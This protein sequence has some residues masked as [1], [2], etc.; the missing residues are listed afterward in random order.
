MYFLNVSPG[1]RE[2]TINVFH[3]QN[4]ETKLS[5]MNQTYSKMQTKINIFFIKE[6]INVIDEG[7]PLCST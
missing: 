3:N 5:K 2:R 1:P 7:N 4:T 6:S